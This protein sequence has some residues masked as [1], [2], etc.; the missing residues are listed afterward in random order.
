MISV[1]GRQRL[2][3]HDKS[4]L[5]RSELA[6]QEVQYLALIAVVHALQVRACV[7]LRA[8]RGR[9]WSCLG[10]SHLV[11]LPILKSHGGDHFVIRAF[12]RHSL[13]YQFPT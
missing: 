6:A 12:G 9:G 4:M 7:V 13:L 2:L 8:V 1:L 5:P 10:K 11:G 3:L